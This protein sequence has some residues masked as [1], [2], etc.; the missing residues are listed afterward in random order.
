MV[1]LNGLSC[2]RLVYMQVSFQL[3]NVMDLFTTSLA[4]VGISPPDDRIID[5]LD[6]TPVLLNRPHSLDNRWAR[7]LDCCRS[8]IKK[9]HK[10]I[11]QLHMFS[12]CFC[13]SV[14]FS[15]HKFLGPIAELKVVLVPLLLS[16]PSVWRLHPKGFLWSTLE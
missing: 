3:S 16:H 2:C 8:L 4:L 9:L 15:Y 14:V 13:S 11:F 5:G 7:K 1:V 6:L 10:N 12:L